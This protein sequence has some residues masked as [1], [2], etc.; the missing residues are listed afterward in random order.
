[1]KYKN[2]EFEFVNLSTEEIDNIFAL[3]S[4]Y[5]YIT[6]YILNSSNA[7]TTKITN[8]VPLYFADI[9]KTLRQQNMLDT[10]L[11]TMS[12]NK[13]ILS[14]AY[15][16]SIEKNKFHFAQLLSSLVIIIYGMLSTEFAEENVKDKEK[17]K[18]K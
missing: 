1:M 13:N 10:M 6:S 7:D 5:N 18:K 17:L 3:S 8:I 12:H 4:I 16:N 14:E 2:H 9:T 15:L 11:S